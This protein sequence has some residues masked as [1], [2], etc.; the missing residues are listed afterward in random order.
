[1]HE[2]VEDRHEQEVKKAADEA[3]AKVRA[4]NPHLDD[5]ALM[6]QVSDRV[7]QAEDARKGRAQVQ[8]NAFPYHMVGNQLQNG[9]GPAVPPVGAFRPLPQHPPV[10]QY[11][12]IHPYALAQVPVFVPQ[13]YVHPQQQQFVQPQQMFQPAPQYYNPLGPAPQ[14][15]HQYVCFHRAPP[16]R[17]FAHLH[18]HYHCHPANFYY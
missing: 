6:I 9:A 16:F 1:L 12:P 4:D 14:Q 13:Q 3:M 15:P 18:A 7:K 17:P 5:A 8:A 10:A 2:N 11:V